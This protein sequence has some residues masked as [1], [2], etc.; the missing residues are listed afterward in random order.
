MVTANRCTL[1]RVVKYFARNRLMDLETSYWQHVLHVLVHPNNFSRTNIA[2]YSREWNRISIH[3]YAFPS[4]VH[5]KNLLTAVCL[6]QSRPTRKRPTASLCLWHRT[7]DATDGWRGRIVSVCPDTR[8]S[9]PT[10]S[11]SAVR[12]RTARRHPASNRLTSVAARTPRR[13]AAR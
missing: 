4:L 9:C 6:Q 12:Y 7:T 8:R 13:S 3:R 1:F 10:T 2:K 5:R 11:H